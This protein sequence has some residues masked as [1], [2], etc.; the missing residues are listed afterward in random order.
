MKVKSY[1]K[2]FESKFSKWEKGVVT[3]ATIHVEN[4]LK[5]KVSDSGSGRTYRQGEFI[6]RSGGVGIVRELPTHTASKPGQPPALDTGTLRRSITR[7]I[8]SER[9]GYAGYTG[10]PLKYGLW[11]ERGTS[12]MQPRPWLKPT[13]TEQQDEVARIMSRAL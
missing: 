1:F 7:D 13:F 11:L 10:T 12:R 4:E 5:K 6:A 3:R 2:D 9:G 8:R